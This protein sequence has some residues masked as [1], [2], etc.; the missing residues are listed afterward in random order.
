[1]NKILGIT[2]LLSGVLLY[3]NK[4]TVGSED[5]S[6][7]LATLFASQKSLSTKAGKIQEEYEHKRLM[8]GYNKKLQK[9]C[10]FICQALAI[11]KEV[12]KSSTF[13][14]QGIQD[15]EKILDEVLTQLKPIPDDPSFFCTIL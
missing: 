3:G 6:Q 14:H 12:K 11:S 15:M 13:P 2:I 10:L 7:K 9:A 1:M 4:P 5:L 8:I